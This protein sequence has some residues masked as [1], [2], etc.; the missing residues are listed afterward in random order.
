[1][2]PPASPTAPRVLDLDGITKR[3]GPVTANED[4][5]LHLDRGEYL[6]EIGRFLRRIGFFDGLG[7]PALGR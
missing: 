4:V 7:P 2:S 3:F 6:R 1:M 5:S